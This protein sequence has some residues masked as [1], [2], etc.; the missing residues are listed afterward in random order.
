MNCKNC[1]KELTESDNFCNNCGAKIIN[2]RLTLKALMTDVAERL[3]KWDNNFFL[4]I[5]KLITHPH[6][7]F[8]DYID[9]VRKRFVNPFTFFAIGIAISITVI[10]QFHDEYI[11]MSQSFNEAQIELM[12]EQIVKPTLKVDSLKIAGDTAKAEKLEEMRHFKEDQLKMNEEFQ[13]NILKHYHLFSF[14]FLPIYALMCLIV[15]GKRYNYAEHLVANAYIQGLLLITI[16]VLL[17]ISLLIHPAIYSLMMPLTMFY[18]G[19]S[20]GKFYKLTIWQSILK[21]LK[22]LL[23]LLTMFFILFLVGVVTSMLFK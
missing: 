23:V 11:E 13:E 3:F 18:Y 21:F 9:G 10:N 16:A 17:V 5:R 22:F 2:E 12:D 1:Q 14:L 4:T 15:F 8:Q 6:L 19:Y 20:Y 7:V